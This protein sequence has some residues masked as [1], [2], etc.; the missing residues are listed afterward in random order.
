MPDAINTLMLETIEK[1]PNA[2]NVPPVNG[3]DL[4]TTI[5]EHWGSAYGTIK[6]WFDFPDQEGCVYQ[7]LSLC[8][9]N[10]SEFSTYTIFGFSEF[11]GALALLVVV[12][13]ITDVRY[14]FRIRVAPLPLLKIAFSVITVVGLG[15]LITDLCIAS[16][17]PVLDL[18]ITYI[19][20]Q[21]LYG[22][23]FLLTALLWLFYALIKPPRFGKRNA[24]KYLHELYRYIL[25]ASEAELPVIA[26]ELGR[27]AREII[28]LSEQSPSRLSPKSSNIFTKIFRSEDK[29]GQYAYEILLMIGTRRL[30]RYMIAS[31]PATVMEFFS[32]F[33]KNIRTKSLPIGQF[34]RNISTEAILN[35]E[36]ILYHEDDGYNSGWL[37][38]VRPFSNVI[39]GDYDLIDVLSRNHSSPL[40]IDYKIAS[41]LDPE[42]FEAYTRVTLITF[43]EYIKKHPSGLTNSCALNRAFSN[44]KSAGMEIYKIKNLPDYYNTDVYQKFRI[45]VDFIRSVIKLLG[46]HSKPPP[47]MKSSDKY[48]RGDIYDH[49]VGLMFETIFNASSIK[50]DRDI[51]W[52]IHYNTVW[53]NFFY[54]WEDGDAVKI[55]LYRLRRTLY[56]EICR[57]SKS[58]NYKSARILAICLNVMGLVV[59][60]RERSINK[61][62][63][64]LHKAMVVWIKKNYLPLIDRQPDVAKACI[65]GS[66]TFDEDNK[67]IVKSYIKG[68]N[69]EE[70]TESL[71]LT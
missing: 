25:Q 42:Q 66:I 50:Q 30:C 71:N 24:K 21:F 28:N 43:E 70:P 37:G 6:G 60:G 31:A 61:H 29:T 14:K 18:P 12:Y 17:R 8:F 23:L 36:S 27:T 19:I 7:V 32:E 33:S 65:I 62:Y 13:T 34:V 10:P 63:R 4:M 53:S 5:S 38:Y 54:G 68:L 67:K 9:K 46:K 57:L 51:C 11:I 59:Y 52:S 49:I 44:I 20:F 69:L 40:D 48:K 16:Q 15:S 22:F 3:V 35:K 45:M 56:D 55:I 47:R 58:P 64:A 1:S 26:H 2:S 39:Y 41:H